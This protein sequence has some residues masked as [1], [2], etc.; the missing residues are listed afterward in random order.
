MAKIKRDE[1]GLLKQ[2]TTYADGITVF[3]ALQSIGFG[4]AVGSPSGI[5]VSVHRHPIII[6]II[7]ALS[8]PFYVWLLSLCHKSED[9]LTVKPDDSCIGRAVKRI[10]IVRFTIVSL[11]T[12]LCVAAALSAIEKIGP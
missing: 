1:K 2:I 11:A 7:A 12:T 5:A 3:A 9:E 6:S 8:L 10:R 4:L